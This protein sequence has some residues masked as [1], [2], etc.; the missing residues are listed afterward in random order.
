ML[1]VVD[2]RHPME[3]RPFRVRLGIAALV[4][5]AIHLAAAGLLVAGSFGGRAV[6]VTIGAALFAY[7]RGALHALDFDHV[8]MIDNSIRK[9]VA[10]GRRPASVG[11][12][13][14]AGH[15]TV[16][17]ALGVLVVTGSGIARSLL[18]DGSA[19]A[20]VLS[21]IGMSVSGLYLLL[22]AINNLST[23]VSTWRLRRLLRAE[24][25]YPVPADALTARGPAA[26][27]MTAPLRW[28]KRPRHIYGLGLLFGLGFDTAST[29]GLAMMT[30]AAAIS[31]APPFALLAL[32]LMFAAAMTL[33]DTING[34]MM[35]KMYESAQSDPVRKL[36]YNLL[37]T[38]LGVLSAAA[39]SIFTL[40]TLLADTGT[41][42]GPLGAIARVD[43]KYFGFGLAGLFALVGLTVVVRRLGRGPHGRVPAEP[44]QTDLDR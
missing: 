14:S 7:G 34:V 16:V 11:L 43:T 31:G 42:D 24:P 26:R 10:E 28:V 30:S 5:L 4:I 20:A 39:V 12:A 21:I 6:T 44:A 33:G 40:T 19:T 36:N 22:I 35:L 15:S 1:L 23:F 13:F 25:S 17:L 32:P 38:G 2:N 9:F 37:I 3:S 8:S 29:I 41:V 18:T 27:L